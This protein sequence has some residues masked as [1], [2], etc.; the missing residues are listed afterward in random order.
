[1]LQ[2]SGC[3]IFS[4]SS[5]INYLRT[6]I[7]TN[8]SPLRGAPVG[9]KPQGK[10]LDPKQVSDPDASVEVFSTN[11]YENAEQGLSD[12]TI[13]QADVGNLKKM[14]W[15]GFGDFGLNFIS[16]TIDSVLKSTIHDFTIKNSDC[17]NLENNTFF[18]RCGG[19][20]FNIVINLPAEIKTRFITEFEANLKTEISKIPIMIKNGPGEDEPTIIKPA[21]MAI[22]KSSPPN[23]SNTREV[24][25][26]MTTHR[27]RFPENLSAQEVLEK[28]KIV[29]QY[30][31]TADGQILDL[32][33]TLDILSYWYSLPDDANPN[34]ETYLSDLRLRSHNLNQIYTHQDLSEQDFT[35]AKD[36]I[37]SNNPIFQCYFDLAKKNDNLSRIISPGQQV[38]ELFFQKVMLSELTKSLTDPVLGPNILNRSML[39]SLIENGY[40]STVVPIEAKPK[41]INDISYYEGNAKIQLIKK[42]F[43]NHLFEADSIPKNLEKYICLGRAGPVIFLCVN[44]TV[45]NAP[46]EIKAKI[47]DCLAKAEN[48]KGVEYLKGNEKTWFPL[49]VSVQDL[50]N[51][52]DK[53]VTMKQLYEQIDSKWYSNTIEYFLQQNDEFINSIANSCHLESEPKNFEMKCWNLLFKCSRGEHYCN[54][55]IQKLEAKIA[56]AVNKQESDDSLKNLKAIFTQI[57]SRIKIYNQNKENSLQGEQNASAEEPSVD[58]NI[59]YFKTYYTHEARSNIVNFNQV[60]QLVGQAT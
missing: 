32:A 37:I 38:D 44:A 53:V 52:T 54:S 22:K 6:L 14:N 17:A 23:E 15:V 19:D 10:A 20:E 57:L 27:D 50:E 25:A 7:Q 26:F 3:N 9:I 29:Y 36:D 1:M 51:S 16:S 59:E 55:L 8:D 39:F 41:A 43:L 21:S 45:K 49:A 12:V 5:L 60:L 34:L 42:S 13:L 48:F 30:S 46:T 18:A 33:Q 35:R 40:I 4:S 11:K 47:K 56:E 28:A 58:M 2:A 31:I 24:E